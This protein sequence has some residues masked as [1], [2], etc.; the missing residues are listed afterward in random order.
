MQIREL[1]RELESSAA[2]LAP[3]SVELCGYA[4]ARVRRP[5]GADPFGTARS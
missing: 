4:T 5:P 2:P 3:T 1:N